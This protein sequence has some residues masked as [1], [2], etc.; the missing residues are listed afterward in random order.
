MFIVK[1]VPR[2]HFQSEGNNNLFKL[3]TFSDSFLQTLDKQGHA[4]GNLNKDMSKMYSLLC[5]LDL[6]K[7]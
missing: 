6:M 5:T 7:A 4:A 3:N 2:L 1:M